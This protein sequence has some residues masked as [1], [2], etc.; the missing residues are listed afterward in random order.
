MRLLIA[1]WHGQVA[2]ALIEAAPA[3]TEIKALAAG[4]PALDVRDPRSVERAFGDIMPDVVINSAAYTAVDQAETD[5]DAA[6]ALN[7]D[8]AA[9]LARAAARRNV[10][11]IHLSTH[12]VFDGAKSDPYVEIDPTCPATVYGRSKLEGEE[13]VREAAPR[14]IIIRTGWVFS[15]A[16]NT[17]V[18]RVLASAAGGER[19]RIVDDQTGNPT[20][21]P[22]LASTVLDVA[23]RIAARADTDSLWGTYHVAGTGVTSWH[24]F[25]AAVLTLSG[26]RSAVIEPIASADYP[27]K[28]SRPHNS[29]LTC[30]KFEAAFGIVMPPWQEGVAACV[31]RLAV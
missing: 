16:A 1:G 24:G 20:Y 13:A 19:L 18:P 10:P 7:R 12:Y 14:H 9:L 29:A 22:H 31:A 21:A 28:A 5:Q 8:G 6:F 23:L 26:S 4:R 30:A 15:A 27:A 2:R 17:F 3:R 11:V 25:A